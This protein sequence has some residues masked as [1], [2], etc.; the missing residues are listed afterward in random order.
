MSDDR[1]QQAHDRYEG[2]VF[3]ALMSD[4]PLLDGWR[5]SL[6]DVAYDLSNIA[7]SPLAHPDDVIRARSAM[8]A[9]AGLWL[10]GDEAEALV[11]DLY[12]ELQDGSS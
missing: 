5:E 11:L 7:S 4:R 10:T 3:H 9:L 12:P 6:H 2:T 1:L 8:R